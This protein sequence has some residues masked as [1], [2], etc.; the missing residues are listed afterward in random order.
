MQDTPFSAKQPQLVP[1]TAEAQASKE[2][3]LNKKIQ[4]RGIDE[5]ADDQIRNLKTGAQT[6]VVVDP[7][8]NNQL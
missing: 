4:M 5:V 2:Y 8:A 7:L 6:F 3:M 1:G